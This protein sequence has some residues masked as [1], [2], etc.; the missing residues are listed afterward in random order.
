MAT[1]QNLTLAKCTMFRKHQKTVSLFN[2]WGLK[3][4]VFSKHCSY[5]PLTHFKDRNQYYNRKILS[6]MFCWV[7]FF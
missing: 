5:V 3:L 7:F 1:R 2:K 4:Y 6:V